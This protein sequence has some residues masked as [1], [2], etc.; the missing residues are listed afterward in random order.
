VEASLNIVADG[1]RSSSDGVTTLS[2]RENVTEAQFVAARGLCTAHRLPSSLL[3]PLSTVVSA[4]A[5]SSSS[6]STSAND[7]LKTAQFSRSDLPSSTDAPVTSSELLL[8]AYDPTKLH[9]LAEL[10]DQLDY[11]VLDDEKTSDL[12]GASTAIPSRG[13]SD[14]LCYGTGTM[15]LSGTCRISFTLLFRGPLSRLGRDCSLNN[16]ASSQLCLGTPFCSFCH[17]LMHRV[18]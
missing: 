18:F 6:A 5:S 7:Y 12:P 4:M 14:D 9:P 10:G 13:F 17:M 16:I 1:R 3:S 11:L 2:R 15:Y 8:S